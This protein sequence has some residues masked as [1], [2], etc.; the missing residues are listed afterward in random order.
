MQTFPQLHN[1]TSELLARLADIGVQLTGDSE[2]SSLQHVNAFWKTHADILERHR[3][4]TCNVA[5]LGLT[6]AGELYQ[7]HP[8][9]SRPDPTC[10]CLQLSRGGTHCMRRMLHRKVDTAQRADWR[11]DIADFQCPGDSSHRT[12]AACARVHGACPR[13]HQR[14]AAHHWRGSSARAPGAP[15]QTGAPA[16]RPRRLLSRCAPTAS[17]VLKA[18]KVLLCNPH[19]R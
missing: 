18:C 19:F 15:Q 7:A 9:L 5:V 16:V 2:G 6:K 11:A 8:L 13:W 12:V 3:N 4:A 10:Q 1:A 17:G 14:R